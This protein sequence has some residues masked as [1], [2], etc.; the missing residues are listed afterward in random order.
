[1]LDRVELGLVAEMRLAG[2]ISG[3]AVLLVEL[4]NGW[5][6]FLEAVRVAGN[7]D[8]RQRRADRNFLKE[9]PPW[10]D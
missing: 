4:G 6:L 3:I 9:N 1:M 5:R 8:D 7:D 10:Q 2:K